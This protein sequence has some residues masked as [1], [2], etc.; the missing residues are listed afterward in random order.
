M[1]NIWF[2]HGSECED[3][4]LL[5]CDAFKKVSYVPPL[6]IGSP[7]VMFFFF[8][9]SVIYHVFPR[10]WSSTLEVY[11]AIYFDTSAKLHGVASRNSVIFSQ[12][13]LN[14]YVT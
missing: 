13:V 7:A 14:V 6:P 4:R 2:S 10:E 5:W 9:L 3:Y 8:S 1:Y 11:Q 12:Y